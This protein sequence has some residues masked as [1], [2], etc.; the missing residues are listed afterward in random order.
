M[1]LEISPRQHYSIEFWLWSGMPNEAHDQTGVLF[2]WGSDRL[3]IT[4]R[5]AKHFGRL[6]FNEVLGG[7]FHLSPSTYHVVNREGRLARTH[8]TQWDRAT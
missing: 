1:V 3:W 5:E 8:V 2:E 6:A 7:D 4:W